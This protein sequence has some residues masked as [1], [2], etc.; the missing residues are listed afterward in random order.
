[1]EALRDDEP[2]NV[3]R[4]SLSMPRGS[5]IADGVARFIEALDAQTDMRLSIKET[6]SVQTVNNVLSGRFRLGIIRYRVQ[7]ERTSSTFWM[8]G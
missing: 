3:Q 6:N 2:G 4:L 7:H 1:M 5:Y 8:K